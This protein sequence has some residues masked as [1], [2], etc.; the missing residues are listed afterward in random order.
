[1]LTK[2]RLGRGGLEVSALGLGCMGMSQSYGVRNDPESIATLQRAIELDPNRAHFW[3]Q[4]GEAYE[5]NPQW[6]GRVG[7]RVA[8]IF[9]EAAAKPVTR[10]ISDNGGR[11][12][13]AEMLRGK[14]V[15]LPSGFHG[16]VKVAR[17]ARIG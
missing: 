17:E 5:R 7:A 13:A 16:T 1:M 11:R 9:R 3:E 14:D 15:E 12:R 2:R 4:R 8:L 6:A 10:G